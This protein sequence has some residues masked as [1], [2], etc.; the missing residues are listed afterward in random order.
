MADKKENKLFGI[1]D[2]LGMENDMK[3]LIETAGTLVEYY[4]YLGKMTKAYHDGLIEAGF[5]NEEA[6]QITAKKS[7]KDIAFMG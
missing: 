6:L 4:K 1:V 5:T 3:N 2:K 7:L